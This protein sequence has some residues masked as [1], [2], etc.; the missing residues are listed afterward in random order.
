MFETNRL[1]IEE[2]NDTLARQIIGDGDDGN[3]ITSYLEALPENAVQD[4]IHDTDGV[5]SF[6][7]SLAALRDS[8]DIRHYGA[9]NRVKEPVAHIGITSWSSKTPELQITVVKEH[10][11]LG[12]GHEFLQA[13]I[14][15][16]FQNFDIQ[17]FVYRLRK[18][19]IPSEKI[20]QSLGG[21][22]QEPRSA[23]E[24]LTLKTYYIYPD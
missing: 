23:L 10:R 21:V 8:S 4:A 3:D 5:L 17:F 16:L 24:Q 22:L 12:Y 13:L 11:H 9:W 14:P 19:N 1:V 2:I 7:Q 6:V 18:D 15:W 20:V